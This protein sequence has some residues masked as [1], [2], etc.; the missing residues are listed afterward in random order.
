MIEF[1]VPGKPVP[2]ARARVVRMKSGGM[3]SYTPEATANYELHVKWQ[4]AGV[5]LGRPP[6]EGPLRM[7]L[8]ICLPVPASWSRKKTDAAIEGLVLPTVK[9]DASN[10]QKAIEDAMNSIVYRDDSQLCEITTR[11]CYSVQPGVR[12]TV[13]QLDAAAS[14]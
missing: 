1:F 9:P 8:I 13:E 12:I 7:Q 11:K 5:M 2:K 6:L 4:A 14:N 10:I 3:R